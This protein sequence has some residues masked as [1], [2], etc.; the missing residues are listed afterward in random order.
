MIDTITKFGLGTF[1]VSKPFVAQ[2][3]L[4]SLVTRLSLCVVEIK[5][6]IDNHNSYITGWSPHF[7]VSADNATIPLY[8]VDLLYDQEH[9]YLGIRVAPPELI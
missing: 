2:G 5:Q 6:H 9:N 7:T 3:V 4:A 1:I 8:Q